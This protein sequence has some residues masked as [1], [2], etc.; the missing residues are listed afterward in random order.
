MPS[1]GLCKLHIHGFTTELNPNVVCGWWRINSAGFNKFINDNSAAIA[2]RQHALSRIHAANT[3]LIRLSSETAVKACSRILLRGRV[4]TQQCSL[5]DRE[6]RSDWNMQSAI[7]TCCS[8]SFLDTS[9]KSSQ[10]S[11]SYYLSKILSS[12]TLSLEF[13]METR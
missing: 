9:V 13:P 10:T 5:K 6:R 3:T 7:K 8:F 1:L 11:E 2:N 12:T 4:V